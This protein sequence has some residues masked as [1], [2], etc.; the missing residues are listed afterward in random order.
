MDVEEWNPQ[1]NEAQKRQMLQSSVALHKTKGILHSLK[2][3]LAIFE[4]RI[5]VSE[6]FEHGGTPH[7]FRLKVQINNSETLSLAQSLDPHF[8]AFVWP[9]IDR[10]KPV[11][12]HYKVHLEFLFHQTV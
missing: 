4:V 3:A 1:W 5:E 11:C 8:Y 6:W 10:L 2:E 12:N 9:L 7:N